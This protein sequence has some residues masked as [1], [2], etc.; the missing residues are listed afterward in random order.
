LPEFGTKLLSHELIHTALRKQFGKQ[1]AIPKV[2]LI[3]FLREHSGNAKPSTL[4]WR[5]HELTQ[6]GILTRIGYG[7]YQLNDRPIYGP[8]LSPTLRKIGDRVKAELPFTTC[9]VWDTR[10]LA[11]FMI[12]QPMSFLQ[13]IEV[14][15]EA[16]SSVYQLLQEQPVRI[17]RKNPAVYRYDDWLLLSQRGLPSPNPIIVKPLITEAPVQQ[18]NKYTTAPLEKVLVDLIADSELFFAYQEELPYIFQ[19][20]F[21]KFIINRDKLRRYARRR[22]R[23]DMLEQLLRQ[24]LPTRH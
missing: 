16:V 1:E 7:Q 18:Q 12:Q 10:I 9:C 22:N 23:V 6:A 14:N 2:A 17:D 8:D 4:A 5:L 11:D 3:D 21:A 24:V 13:L 19:T 15:K 20:A